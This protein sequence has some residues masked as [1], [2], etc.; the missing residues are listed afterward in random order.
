MGKKRGEKHQGEKSRLQELH[1]MELFFQKGA[2]QKLRTPK[3][4]RF[5]SKTTTESSFLFGGG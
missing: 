3:S 5:T 1:E 4:H 2:P